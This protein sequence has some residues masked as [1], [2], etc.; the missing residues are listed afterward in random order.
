MSAFREV[1]GFCFPDPSR[2]PAGGADDLFPED[3]YH[4]NREA[5][6]RDSNG[7][8]PPLHQSNSFSHRFMRPEQ[9][10]LSKG[11]LSLSMANA[12]RH[13]L[14]DWVLAAVLWYVES[15]AQSS[16]H[17][18][19][20]CMGIDN[21]DSVRGSLALMNRSPGHKREF[22]LNDISIQHTFAEHERVPPV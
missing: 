3:N 8:R 22:S 20:A 16:N 12:V 6:E 4:Q 5:R 7:S 10:D 15:Q 2:S 11:V 19:M 17:Q 21:A 1:V 18:A 9:D 14:A 13:Y